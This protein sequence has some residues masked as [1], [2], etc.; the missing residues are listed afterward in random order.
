MA[1]EADGHEGGKRAEVTLAASFQPGDSPLGALSEPRFGIGVAGAA[2]EVEGGL[3][4]RLGFCGHR[5]RVPLLKRLRSGGDRHQ[6][7][8]HTEGTSKTRHLV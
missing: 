6:P 7:Q 1:Q 4:I 2:I 5:P 8:R 3:R